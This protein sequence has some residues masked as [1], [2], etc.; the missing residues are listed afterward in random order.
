MTIWLVMDTLRVIFKR[1]RM[2]APPPSFQVVQTDAQP[3]AHGSATPQVR[4]CF[5]RHLMLAAPISV[6]YLSPVLATS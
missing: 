3:A 5:A 1:S 4:G 6:S 2:G